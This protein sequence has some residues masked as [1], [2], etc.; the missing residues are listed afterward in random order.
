[1]PPR[2]PAIRYVLL[3]GLHV[4]VA[5][6]A[7]M[8]LAFALV[9]AEL[10]VPSH[11]ILA[12]LAFLVALGSVVLAYRVL[13]ALG[14][15]F[16]I[17]LLVMAPVVFFYAARIYP[18]TT[19]GKRVL[20]RN[21][22]TG[23][24]QGFRNEADKLESLLGKQGTAVTLLRPA[25]SVEIEGNRIDAVS[26]SEM[27]TAGTKVEVIRISGLRVIVKAASSV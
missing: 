22:P 26:E 27:I 19:V 17:L 25:G 15:V 23:S 20:L 8:L 5:A 21:P 10:I 24:V 13:P 4:I 7:L 2:C 1:M 14:I 9:A 3:W 12:I 6:I 11:G 16:L 18:N